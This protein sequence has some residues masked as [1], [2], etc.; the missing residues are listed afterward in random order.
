M[1]VQGEQV[2]QLLAGIDTPSR[3]D[4]PVKT[5]VEF[6]GSVK[7]NILIVSPHLTAPPNN[8]VRH[9]Y[10]KTLDLSMLALYAKVRIHP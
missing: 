2:V 9:E 1:A 8:T 5:H 3:L 10:S 4:M 6:A 7:D